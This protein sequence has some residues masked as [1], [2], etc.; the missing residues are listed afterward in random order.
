MHDNSLKTISP[1]RQLVAYDL[2]DAT[3]RRV[4]HLVEKNNQVRHS[5][6]IVKSLFFDQTSYST[7][8]RIYQMSLIFKKKE[9]NKKFIWFIPDVQL[10]MARMI[11]FIKLLHSYLVY[12]GSIM[13]SG[14]KLSASIFE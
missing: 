2:V 11:S 12:N 5:V 8:R 13:D 1:I 7:E 4:R 14:L 9:N 3:L 10:I 6:E